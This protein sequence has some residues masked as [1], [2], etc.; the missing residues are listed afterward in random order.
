MAM[1]TPPGTPGQGRRPAGTR[2]RSGTGGQDTLRA[3]EVD[4]C[5]LYTQRFFE[6][7]VQSTARLKQILVQCGSMLKR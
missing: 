1:A 6:G 5:D 7:G 3:A 4:F 2:A